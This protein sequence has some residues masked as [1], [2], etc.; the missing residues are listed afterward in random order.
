MSFETCPE[1][2]T[3]RQDLGTGMRL[4]LH[5]AGRLMEASKRDGSCFL[6]AERMSQI[7]KAIFY[8]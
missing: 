2:Q 8:A 5:L 6:A 7:N 4:V 1:A 3:Q